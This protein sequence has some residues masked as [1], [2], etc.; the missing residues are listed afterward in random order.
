MPFAFISDKAMNQVELV[1]QFF[2]MDAAWAST[3]SL[4]LQA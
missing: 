2:F 3:M 1:S 4:A